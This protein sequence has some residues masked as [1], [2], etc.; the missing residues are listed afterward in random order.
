MRDVFK[1]WAEINGLRYQSG[2]Y[3]VTDRLTLRPGCTNIRS[4]KRFQVLDLD[5]NLIATYRE[6]SKARI[7]ADRLALEDLIEMQTRAVEVQ[8]HFEFAAA[9]AG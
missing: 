6:E 5:Q 3:L 7:H 4:L 2:T 1:A 9:I 8:R